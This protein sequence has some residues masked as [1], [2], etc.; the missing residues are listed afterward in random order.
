MPPTIIDAA[1]GPDGTLYAVSSDVP[2][3]GE[4][5]ACTSRLHAYRAHEW[6]VEA[7]WFGWLPTALA[8]TSS[9]AIVASVKQHVFLIRRGVVTAQEHPEPARGLHCFSEGTSPLL[10]G[11]STGYYLSVDPV[12]ASLTARNLRDFGVEKPGRTI[13]AILEHRGGLVFVGA[14]R[15]ALAV[16]G[17]HV[18]ALVPAGP[19]AS[20]PTFHAAVVLRDTLYFASHGHLWSSRIEGVRELSVPP[21]VAAHV[22]A[23]ASTG[24]ALLVGGSDVLSVSGDGSDCRALF[25]R[26]EEF[27]VC[28]ILNAPVAPT[29]VYSDGLVVHLG[30]DTPWTS[31]IIVAGGP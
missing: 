26:S 2:R 20:G 13:F 21:H 1:V 25:R 31:H 23:L 27:Y 22:G 18:A 30:A 9:F 17:V 7:E 10:I 24:Q 14:H 12:T 5:Y 4:D 11:G 6:R 15:L 28:R 3:E 16:T 29:A 19:T 8:V